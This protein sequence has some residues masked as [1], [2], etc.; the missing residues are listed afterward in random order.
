MKELE[1]AKPFLQFDNADG[2][3]EGGADQRG[4]SG[5]VELVA[6][7]RLRYRERH[8]LERLATKRLP[9]RIR[10]PRDRGRHI[11]ATIGR[12]AGEDRR[13]Q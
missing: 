7:Q 13:P 9:P 2:E 8:V 6:G 10:L 1:D 4:Q 12:K 3:I 11:E 5:G